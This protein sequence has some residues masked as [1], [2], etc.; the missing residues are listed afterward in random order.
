MTTEQRM[1]F[2]KKCTNREM[3]LKQGILCKVTGRKADFEGEC[4]HY[5][6][7]ESVVLI[8]DQ[9]VLENSEVRIHLSNKQLDKLRSEQNYQLALII[10]IIVG[11]IGAGLWAAITVATEYQIGYMAIAIGAGVGFSIRI[12]G[13]GIDQKFGITGAIIALISCALG[14][15][16]SIIA[17]VGQYENLSFF[18]T[19]LRFDYSQLIPIMS[20]SFSVM[21]VLFYGL[22]AYEGY[23]FAFKPI[24]KEEV[25]EL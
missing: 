21:D 17:F 18:D 2:C 7:D 1:T 12:F 9:T 23:K 6:L 15:F 24:T 5:T 14:N 3:D 11:V 22:A 10:G 19:L 13:K 4:L 8:E 25:N 16:F 20:E